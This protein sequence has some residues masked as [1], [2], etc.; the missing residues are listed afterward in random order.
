MAE[1]QAS[2]FSTPGTTYSELYEPPSGKHASGTLWICNTHATDAQRVRVGMQDSWSS[3]APTFF[4]LD[5]EIEGRSSGNNTWISPSSISIDNGQSLVVEAA[6]SDVDF[7]FTFV[8]DDD[9]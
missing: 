1:R 2:A 8:E 6:S 7:T 3:G 9:T 5:F 4:Q